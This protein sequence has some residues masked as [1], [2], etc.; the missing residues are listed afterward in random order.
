MFD[1]EPPSESCE[2]LDGLSDVPRPKDL[3]PMCE[4]SLLAAESSVTFRRGEERFGSLVKR[5]CL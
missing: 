5:F 3:W 1:G 2:D 4:A